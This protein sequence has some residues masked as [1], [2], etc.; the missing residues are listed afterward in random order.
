MSNPLKHEA[1]ARA[2]ISTAYLFFFNAMQNADVSAYGIN[3]NP[4]F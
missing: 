4:A 3:T 2:L 1:H